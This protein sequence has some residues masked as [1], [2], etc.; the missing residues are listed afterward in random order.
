[1]DTSDVRGLE[2]HTFQRFDDELNG[3]VTEMLKMGG[4]VEKQLQD[5]LRAI[6]TM[7]IELA[8]AVVENESSVNDFDLKIEKMCSQ[9]IAMRQPT[10]SDL[11]LVLGVSKSVGDLERIGDEASKIAEMVI[12]SHENNDRADRFTEIGH[13][14]SKVAKMLVQA[15]DSYGRFDAEAAIDV[16]R[17]DKEINREYRFA[18]RALVTYMMED[19][20]T[21]ASV[22]NVMWALRSVERIGDHVQNIAE[23]LIY[24][25]KGVDVRHATLKQIKK[26][27][28]NN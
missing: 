17:L 22:L 2:K 8:E 6:D 7:D 24:T 16:A 12:S 18:M 27:V 23:H 3:L 25:V 9:V 28:R 11:R 26:Q 1:M 4:L 10:A 13:V 20:R 15:L 14:A 21:I 5:A 19:P